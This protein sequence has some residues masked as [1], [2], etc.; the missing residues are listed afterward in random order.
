VAVAFFEVRVR[1]GV[2]MGFADIL[3]RG[4]REKG[5]TTVE[6]L[7]VILILFIIFFTIVELSRAWWTKNT[8]NNA[9]RIG[10]RVAAVD[11]GFT[12]LGPV[13]CS[14]LNP[15]KAVVAVCTDANIKPDTSVTLAITT[16]ETPAGIS[17]GDIIT[18]TATVDFS[19]HSLVPIPAGFTSIPAEASMR[20]E[21]N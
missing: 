3:K 21:L 19:A 1:G 14:A 2:T 10:A 8:L 20:Y 11:P 9:V 17:A 15:A 4:S 18:V 13:L 6:T 7:L 12:E 16:D 5:Q